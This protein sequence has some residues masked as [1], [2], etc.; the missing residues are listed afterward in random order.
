[1]WRA[2][3]LNNS[4]GHD[5]RFFEKKRKNRLIRLRSFTEMIGIVVYEDNAMDESKVCVIECL[6]NSSQCLPHVQLHGTVE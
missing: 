5:I 2:I 1:M 6:R 4:C 3:K